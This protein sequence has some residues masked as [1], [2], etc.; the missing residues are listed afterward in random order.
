MKQKKRSQADGGSGV[1]S[2]RLGND[3][4]CRKFRELTEDGGAQVVIRDDPKMAW[5]GHRRESRNSLLD[6]T[7][8]AIERE[9]LFG[10]TLATERP[11][12]RAPATGENYG[13]EVRVRLH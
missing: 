3:L 8:L 1:A 5:R 7:V 13:I 12:A 2:D 10:A 4:L 9:Q 11:E 6:H